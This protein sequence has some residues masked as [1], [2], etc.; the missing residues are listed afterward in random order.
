[1]K[2]VLWEFE[3]NEFFREL[4]SYGNTFIDP[5]KVDDIAETIRDGHIILHR[6]IGRNIPTW[7]RDQFNLPV[8]VLQIFACKSGAVGRIHKDG[9]AR[10]SSFNIPVANTELGFVEWFDKDIPELTINNSYTQIR[11]TP[12]EI[13]ESNIRLDYD[14]IFRSRIT[15]PSVLNT[16]VWHRVDNTENNHIRYMLGLR[17]KNN[18]TFNELV[19]S[20]KL[21]S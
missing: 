15:V 4:R 5:A 20:V 6:L 8:E 14:P 3:W 2:S 16:D 21:C 11:I 19:E 9:L 12:A 13:D 1:M 18:P 17:F 7:I 10:K